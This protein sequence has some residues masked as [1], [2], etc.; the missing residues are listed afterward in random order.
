MYNLKTCPQLSK[1]WTGFF[2]SA[3]S[4]HS[5]VPLEESHHKTSSEN[6][7]Q[8]AIKSLKN[9]WMEMNNFNK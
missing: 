5:F 7:L 8:T 4:S 2:Y 9:D 6:L 1:L 3:N